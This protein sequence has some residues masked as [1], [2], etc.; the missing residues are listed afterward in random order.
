MWAP[1]LALAHALICSGLGQEPDPEIPPPAIP[2]IPESVEKMPESNP[3]GL[4]DDNTLIPELPP[5]AVPIREMRR[6]PASDLE[7]WME[8]EAAALDPVTEPPEP[9]A[10]VVPNPDVSREVAMNQALSTG[11]T[12]LGSLGGLNG[13][14]TSPFL[15]GPL[16]SVSQNGSA[17]RPLR[18]GSFDVNINASTGVSGTHTGGELLGDKYVTS[19]LFQG[20]LTALLG[21]NTL[22]SLWLS[23]DIGITYPESPAQGRQIGGGGSGTGIDQT[24]SLMANVVFPE[25][26]K[27]KFALGLE[28]ASLSGFDRDTGGRAKRQIA[29]GSFIAS[30]LGGALGWYRVGEPAGFLASVIGAM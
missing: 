2:A 26:R 15:T 7:A 13:L 6:M 29:T 17:L 8:E 28:Y 27:V 14:L 1:A 4:P 22:S 20:G 25:M 24:F 18:W 9:A 21:R 12:L 23:Y 30:Y 16:R 5:G 11:E 10:P 3:P 19:G